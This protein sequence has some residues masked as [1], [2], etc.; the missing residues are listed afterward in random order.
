MEEKN[1]GWLVWLLLY[2]HRHQSILGAAGQIILTPA[3][4]LMV[5][6]KEVHWIRT[7]LNLDSRVLS[8]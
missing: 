7:C 8:Y 3:N 5:I 6:A 1:T 4:Q 2:A